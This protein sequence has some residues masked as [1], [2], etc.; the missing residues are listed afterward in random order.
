[1]GMSR[2]FRCCGSR[3][4][5]DVKPLPRPPFGPEPTVL[6][7]AVTAEGAGLRLPSGAKVHT[8]SDILTP[9]E[10]HGLWAELP[11]LSQVFDWS[12]LFS[13][14]LHGCNLDTLFRRTCHASPLIL[15]VETTLGQRFGGYCT[16]PLFVRDSS[17]SIDPSIVRALQP[18]QG[19]GQGA[20]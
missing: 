18:A 10:T 15:L 6:P 11:P 16:A 2:A 13:T 5:P 3:P 17:A 1:M 4:Q 14:Q 9:E 7:T 12:L 19:A 20:G 8:L